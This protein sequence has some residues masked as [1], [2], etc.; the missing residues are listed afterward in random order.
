MG[1]TARSQSPELAPAT[2]TVCIIKAI[3][4]INDM[5]IPYL[6]MT[7]KQAADPDHI[8]D[9]QFQRPEGV[10]ADAGG[11]YHYAAYSGRSCGRSR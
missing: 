8:P 5:Y 3:N 6:Y 9:R 11:R 4:I 1:V 7:E 2:A 10:L